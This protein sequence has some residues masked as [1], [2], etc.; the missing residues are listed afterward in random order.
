M[1][2][3]KVIRMGRA[4]GKTTKSLELLQ[5]QGGGVFVTAY[6][7]QA[8]AIVRKMGFDKVAIV[9]INDAIGTNLVI[10]DADIHEITLT[11]NTPLELREI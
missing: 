10:D 4:M 5:A 8:M 7:G 9:S 1:M 11:T 6:P 2:E 3:V